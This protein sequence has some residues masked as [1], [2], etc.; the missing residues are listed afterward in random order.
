L[1]TLRF[2][3]RAPSTGASPKELYDAAIDM[4]HWAEP[5]GVL[6]VILSE[7]HVTGDG[8]LPSPMILASALAARTTTL[9]IT[10]AVVLLPLYQPIRLAEEMIILDIIS[11]GRVGYVAAIGYRPEEYDLFGVDFSRRGRIA[12]EQLPLLLAAKSGA[13]FEH[14][15][16]TIQL[17]PSPVTPGGPRVAW[18]GGSEAAAR[19]AGRFGLDFFAQAGDPGL[20]EAYLVEARAHDHEPGSC[21]LPSP[22]VPTTVFVADDVD[23]A[24]DELGPYLMHD[25]R[26][27][28]SI[29][30]RDTNSV[31][32][33]FA[34]TVDEL[35]AEDRSHRIVTVEEA[36][37]MVRSGTFLQ[38]QPL[39]GGL[40][41]EIA[42][43]YLRRV[44]DVVM[45]SLRD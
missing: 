29:N 14:L 30:S 3:M 39:V 12:E 41:P 43:P 35:R 36:V 4:A 6:T 27:Y 23:R 5:R 20:E 1:Y 18:G 45:P 15:G 24:W 34:E 16:R 31:S 40:P 33:S 9:P 13:P 2:D 37:S 44:T 11:G 7:H 42:W 38:L 21:I 8:Y 32:I 10:V 28:A 26:S 17:A 25:V 19:R 22:D